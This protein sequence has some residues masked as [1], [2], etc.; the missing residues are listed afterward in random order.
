VRH[1]NGL[2]LGADGLTQTVGDRIVRAEFDVDD[3]GTQAVLDD[4]VDRRREAGGDS[5]Y[6][7][8]GL[9]CA[10][11]ELEAG[12]TAQG[13]QIRARTAVDEQGAAGTDVLGEGILEQRVEAASGQPAVERRFDEGREV[14]GV[15][16][17]AGD[18]DDRFARLELGLFESGCCVFFD[19]IKDVLALDVSD[20]ITP[21]LA[22]AGP[23]ILPSASGSGERDALPPEVAQASACRQLSSFDA[24]TVATTNS[25]HPQ[26]AISRLSKIE[27]NTSTTNTSAGQR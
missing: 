23:P 9:Q 24:R 5:E 19:Q 13:D 14:V 17:L 15:K 12:Q 11:A 27:P 22:E 2:G 25:S 10:T 18:G 16:D 1:H 6:L 21:R 20:G 4:R 26:S 7:V 8:T 3:D